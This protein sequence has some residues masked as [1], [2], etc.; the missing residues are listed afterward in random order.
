MRRCQNFWSKNSAARDEPADASPTSQE[1][2]CHRRRLSALQLGL[3][4]LA[5]ELD[6]LIAV[7]TGRR[8]DLLLSAAFAMI[9]LRN[10][11]W[12]DCEVG[13]NARARSSGS[14]PARLARLTCHLPSTFSESESG[15]CRASDVPA[16]SRRRVDDGSRMPARHSE[17]RII[18]QA[19]AGGR[20]Y[21]KDVT[22]N[23]A[24]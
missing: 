11:H 24:A 22:P 8:L 7:H 10:P 3:A 21:L 23:G 5:A 4:Q 18:N 19:T 1:R 14:R 6:Q 13:S 20:L 9:G 16:V 17:K 2:S 15:L 12:I